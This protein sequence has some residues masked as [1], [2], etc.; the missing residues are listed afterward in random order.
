M[1][2][3]NLQ[4]LVV[5]DNAD[6][7][8]IIVAITKNAFV[9]AEVFLASNGPRGLEL[10]QAHDPD[11]VLLDISMPGMDGYEVCRKLKED[12]RLRDIPVVFLSAQ[13]TDRASR[14]KVLEVGADAFL[15]K[16]IDDVELI[17][18]VRTMAKVRTA[19]RWEE[20]ERNAARQQAQ[21]EIRKLSR[22]IEQSP[23]SVLITDRNGSIEYANP[24][25]TQLTGYT[26]EEVRGCNPRLFKGDHTSAAEYK[27][28]WNNITQGREWRGEFHN[29]KKGGELFWESALISPIVD[30][31]G[32]ITHF[33]AIKE[34]ITE[35]KFLQEKLRQAQK[36]EAVGQLAGGVAHDFNNI[37]AATMLQLALLREDSNLTPDTRE[38]IRELETVARRGAN[39]TRQLLMFSRRS[40]LQMQVLDVKELIENL[41]KMLRRLIGENIDLRFDCEPRLRPVEADEGMLEQVILNLTVNARDAM[42]QGGQITISA[43]ELS[44]DQAAAAANPKRW[45]GQYLCLSVADTGCGMAPAVLERV[46]EPF[47]TTKEVG[48]GTGLGLTTVHRIAA[49]H[50]G[51]VEVDSQVGKGTVFRVFFPTGKRKHA[52]QQEEKQVEA[53][54]SSFQG[55]D[56]IL[57]VEDETKVRQNLGRMLR[58]LGYDVREAANGPEAISLWEKERDHIDL[59]FTDL[60]LPGGM[61]GKD[62]SERFL[63]E[64]PTLRVIVSSGYSPDWVEQ[65]RSTRP[66]IIYLPKPYDGMT[67]GRALRASFD[68]GGGPKSVIGC[69]NTE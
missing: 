17:A 40:V 13:Q 22:V 44:V 60:M 24:R 52:A 31:A 8:E 1:E 63:S 64:K 15:C 33:V 19:A 41:L 57:L 18:Q 68:S 42:P 14:I 54:L 34:D 62:L 6:I 25:F 48:K 9:G 45:P 16:P 47:F 50:K 20:R 56:T 29:R 30:A 35:H 5:D 2:T 67:L 7:Q 4:I 55:S 28:L 3:T 38:S 61:G 21:E 11:V 46:Y 53:A 65:H 51:W 69:R 26:L 59:L 58:L 66:G 32:H 10:A 39:I 43:S 27:Q 23:A 36:M 49:Q 12:A 37:L